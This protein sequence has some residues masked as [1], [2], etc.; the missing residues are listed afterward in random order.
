MVNAHSFTDCPEI[1]KLTGS[2]DVKPINLII[3]E[4]QDGQLLYEVL[5][6]ALKQLS[7]L[8]TGNHFRLY[9]LSGSP[10][11]PAYRTRDDFIRA[12]TLRQ[13]DF[14]HLM[15]GV[16]QLD[17][18]DQIAALLQRYTNQLN[19]TGAGAEAFASFVAPIQQA[20]T[21][22]RRQH[23]DRLRLRLE[24]YLANQW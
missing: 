14:L 24:T 9:R 3:T 21:D 5:G 8:P 7:L 11:S 23:D 10:R 18:L 13:E 17:T 20:V 2:T 15:T 4:N 16:F 1:Q 19:T 6:L 22:L 12:L